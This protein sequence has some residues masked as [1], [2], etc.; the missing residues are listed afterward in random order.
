MVVPAEKRSKQDKHDR[1]AYMRKLQAA[2]CPQDDES[3]AEAP[4]DLAQ[5]GVLEIAGD[6][7]VGRGAPHERTASVVDEQV[8]EAMDA[9]LDDVFL[10]TCV[11]VVRLTAL[12]RRERRAVVPADAAQ[13]D[14]SARCP[15]QL[16]PCPA[17]RDWFGPSIADAPHG[18]LG[19]REDEHFQRAEQEHDWCV[20]KPGPCT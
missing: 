18:L 7:E 11:A 10:A 14:H 2:H 20:S 19:G 9:S 12:R 3:A 17:G 4:L 15:F 8:D 16:A 5:V 13:R 6:E 1:E